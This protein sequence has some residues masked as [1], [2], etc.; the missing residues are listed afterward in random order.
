MSNLLYDSLF[1]CHTGDDKPFLNFADGNEISYDEFLRMAGRFAN[2][3]KAAGLKA[4]DR[5]AVQVEKLG[6]T[7]PEVPQVIYA[8][9]RAACTQWALPRSATLKLLV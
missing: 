5:L 9:I 3:I 2:T 7:K 6:R 1:G 8:N 4:G